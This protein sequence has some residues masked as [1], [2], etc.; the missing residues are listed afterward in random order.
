MPL[1]TI[2]QLRSEAM[3]AGLQ[4]ASSWI[5]AKWLDRL[6]GNSFQ[7]TES[8]ELTEFGAFE[9]N[10]AEA[11][12]L[13]H[14]ADFLFLQWGAEIGMLRGGDHRGHRLST[15]PQPSRGQLRR[16]CVR[17]TASRA[18]I[19]EEAIW[20][21]RGRIFE[22]AI[23]ALPTA[24]CEFTETRLLAALLFAP[25]PMFTDTFWM[26]EGGAL[27]IAGDQDTLSRVRSD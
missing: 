23:L 19:M 20:R 21:V 22:C 10:L 9:A 8:T 1:R 3:Q 13:D 11:V 14:G 24:G 2:S 25:H 4:K 6:A 5:A 12:V 17:A 18:P 26:E 27:S 16:V 7:G 15:L